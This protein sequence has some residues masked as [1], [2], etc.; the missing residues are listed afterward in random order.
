MSETLLM[1]LTQSGDLAGDVPQRIIE[2]SR[3]GVN[4]NRFSD[5]AGE[6]RLRCSELWGRPPC[7]SV[8]PVRFF[9]DQDAAFVAGQKWLKRR[10]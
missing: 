8:Y 1:R 9:R 7:R 2:I 10:L 5:H 3:V 6:F 4:D